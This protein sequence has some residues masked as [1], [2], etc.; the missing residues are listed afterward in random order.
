MRRHHL[1]SS[2]NQQAERDRELTFQPRLVTAKYRRAATARRRNRATAHWHA[3][4]DAGTDGANGT[5]GRVGE[6][7]VVAV[8]A[9][10]WER[11]PAR[12]EML[13]Q[14]VRCGSSRPKQRS[15]LERD[16]L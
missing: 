14:D 4:A 5:D 16:P 12:F 10:A 1:L 13:Y 11:T 9:K 2:F 7:P 6:E 15:T 3:E 8:P